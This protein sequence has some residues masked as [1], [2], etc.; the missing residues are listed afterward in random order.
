MALLPG[1]PEHSQAFADRIHAQLQ[2]VCQSDF[3]VTLLYYY[4]KGTIQ[5]RKFHEASVI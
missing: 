2:P 3:D 1:G 5:S 4:F